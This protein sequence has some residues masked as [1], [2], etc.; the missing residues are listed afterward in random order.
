MSDS[1]WPHGLQLTKLPCPWSFPGKNPRVGCHF[2]LQGASLTQG[3][4][5]HLLCLLH[6]QADFYQG[7]TWVPSQALAIINPPGNID[8]QILASINITWRFC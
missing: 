3:L 6:Q 4:N 1:L 5:L 2:I 7:T 8:A